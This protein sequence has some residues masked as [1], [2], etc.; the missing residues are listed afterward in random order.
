MAENSREKLVGMQ[1]EYVPPSFRN[2]SAGEKPYTLCAYCPL[3]RWYKRNGWSCFC[4]DFRTLSYDGTGKADS[5]VTQC[6]AR[7]LEIVRLQTKQKE[8]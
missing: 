1:T 8:S 2:M 5:P 4:S 7:E 3:A 6:D